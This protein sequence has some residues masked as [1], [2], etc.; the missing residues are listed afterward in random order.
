[1][2]LQ[3]VYFNFSELSSF[4]LADKAH[5]DMRRLNCSQAIVISG[6]SGAG[7]TESQKHILRFY[8]ENFGQLGIIEQRI[9]E[10]KFLEICLKKS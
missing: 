10:G 3:S 5:R 9:L 8:C 6:E 4:F 2:F 1:M 7:K